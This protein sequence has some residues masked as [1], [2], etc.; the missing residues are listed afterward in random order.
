[1]YLRD[2]MTGQQEEIRR[3]EG[4]NQMIPTDWSRDGRHVVYSLSDPTTRFD[5][6][7]APVASG[8]IDDSAAV[9]LV[10]TDAV[11][12]QGQLSPDS[13]WLAYVVAESTTF[14]L[15]VRPFPPSAADRVWKVSID[16]G[17]EPRW[18]ADGKELYFVKS[19]GPR[20]SLWSAAVQL[21]AGG[22]LRT[23]APQRLF[24]VASNLYIIQNNI[25][26][27]SPSPD[28]TRFLVNVLTDTSAPV[29]NVVTNWPSA[30]RATATPDRMPLGSK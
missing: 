18:R 21:A 5:I 20:T 13:K 26:S 19:E 15:Y 28:G 25:W 6:W 29:L 10:A 11:E 9:K 30:I 23:G 17:A 3:L 22:E 8:R 16:G 24:A 4:P 27:Y 1:V 14:E 2:F 7:Y 12:S